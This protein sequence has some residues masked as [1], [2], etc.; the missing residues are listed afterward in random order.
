M[1]RLD[2]KVALISGAARGIGAATAAR[3]CE[4]GASVVIGDVLEEPARATVRDIVERGGQCSFVSLDV[5]RADS[6]TAAIAT[7]VERYGEL[8][9][10][11]NNAGLFIGRDIENS[12][13][14]DWRRL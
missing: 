9:V 11:V 14:D 8:S 1:N 3:M 2:A 6:W 13:F 5:T 4:A 10:L 12:S 7:T